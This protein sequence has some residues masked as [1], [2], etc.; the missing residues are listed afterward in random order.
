MTIILT[1]LFNVALKQKR[2]QADKLSA[3]QTTDKSAPTLDEA[4]FFP[5]PLPKGT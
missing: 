4:G 2:E 5:R 1:L 3:A